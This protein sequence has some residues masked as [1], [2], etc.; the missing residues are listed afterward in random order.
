[1][2]SFRDYLVTENQN[3][4]AYGNRARPPHGFMP[5]WD[6]YDADARINNDKRDRFSRHGV[7]YYKK[8]LSEKEIEKF[9]LMPFGD[10]NRL[11]TIADKLKRENKDIPEYIKLMEEEPDE[12]ELLAEIIMKNTIHPSEIDD[13][14]EMLK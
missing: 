2:K 10:K 11:K 7:V 3:L 13:V 6:S 12:K 8:P 9:E 14:I 4:F 1:M 5:K